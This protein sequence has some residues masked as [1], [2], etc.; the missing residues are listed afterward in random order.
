M[1]E[2]ERGE[3]REGETE[4][5]RQREREAER[6]RRGDGD[7]LNYRVRM[8]KNGI[9]Y[10]PESHFMVTKMSHGEMNSTICNAGKF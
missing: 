3:E 7:C 2:R 8:T 5:E 1:W 4:R 9:F 6:K 10:S